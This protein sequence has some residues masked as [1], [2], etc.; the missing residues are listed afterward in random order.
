MGTGISKGHGSMF[1]EC[2]PGNG[3]AE[4]AGGLLTQDP[5]DQS[6]SQISAWHLSR[7]SGIVQWSSFRTLADWVESSSSRASLF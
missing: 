6:I 5:Q 7:H 1:Y 4:G 3:F 2:F